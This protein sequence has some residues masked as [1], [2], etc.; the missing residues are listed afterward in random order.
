MKK[1]FR[2][3]NKTESEKLGGMTVPKRG[4]DPVIIQKKFELIAKLLTLVNSLPPGTEAPN[5]LIM[6]KIFS[7]K[8]EIHDLDLMWR[9]TDE[10]YFQEYGVLSSIDL[11]NTR[12]P[13]NAAINTIRYMDLQRDLMMM[14]E[15]FPEWEFTLSDVRK[16]STCKCGECQKQ[17][18]LTAKE[19]PLSKDEPSSSSSSSI[20]GLD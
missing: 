1:F 14:R 19:E 15:K 17:K 4:H 11:I 9:L 5:Y 2:M 12:K 16:H 20:E 6:R 8:K 7:I 13:W 3:S 18:L 10:F